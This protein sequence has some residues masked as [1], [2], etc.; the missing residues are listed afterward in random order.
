MFFGPIRDIAEKFNIMQSA[1]ASSE[2]IFQLLDKS[3]EDHYERL[4][5]V[6]TKDDLIGKIEFKNVWFAYNKDEWIL[7]DVSFQ[8]E[9]GETV[10]LVGATGSGKSTMLNLVMK[11]YEIQKGSILLDGINIRNFDRYN[12]RKHIAMVLQDV[13]LFSGDIQQNIRLNN[14]SISFEYLKK[15]A[16]TVRADKFI[17]RLK[18]QFNHKVEENGGTLSQGQRQLVSFA[19]ALAFQPKILILDEATANI[20]SETEKWIQEAL[21]ELM[22]ERTAVVVAHRLSTI[23][24]A[25]KI[26]VMHRGRI[27]EIG[28]HEA[29]MQKKGLYYKLY[30]LQFKKQESSFDTIP[31]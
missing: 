12:L 9:P 16:N 19:R 5:P 10:A 13:F 24:S 20:D 6:V 7:K 2:R 1:M 8:V 22:Q 29:L 14:D 15:V 27:H 18:G 25:N 28:N 3:R 4:Q 30:Q 11:F 26:I 21:E 31:D 23:R 17:N